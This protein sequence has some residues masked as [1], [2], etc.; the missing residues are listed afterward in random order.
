MTELFFPKG[1][2]FHYDRTLRILPH[3]PYSKNIYYY[4]RRI[5]IK[6]DKTTVYNCIQLIF[7]LHL[8]ISDATQGIIDYFANCQPCVMN[9]AALEVE[10]EVSPST[11]EPLGHIL[12]TDLMQVIIFDR[13][14]ILQC[15]EIVSTFVLIV[16]TACLLG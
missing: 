7:H 15:G 5:I 13:L 10:H 14:L 2:F 3:S 1:K 4:I 8:F 6:S 9:A 16:Q 11:C 12:L